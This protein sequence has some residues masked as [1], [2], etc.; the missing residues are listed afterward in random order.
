MGRGGDV[1][2]DDDISSDGADGDDVEGGG[3]TAT[4]I[5]V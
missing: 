2:G 3:D 5:V 1:D 4:C